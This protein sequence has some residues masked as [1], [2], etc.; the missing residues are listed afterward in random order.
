[1]ALGATG[2]SVQTMVLRKGLVLAIIG[3]AL[4]LGISFAL[5][6]LIVG[7]LFEVKPADRFTF[8][9]STGVL[10]V[11]AIMASYLPARRATKVDPLIA[12]RCE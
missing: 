12:L 6:R 2:R 11:A 8:L 7:L 3:V 10:L 9:L 1:M 4:G 5:T